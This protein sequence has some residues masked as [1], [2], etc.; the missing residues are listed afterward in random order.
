MGL[1]A[2]GRRAKGSAG[3]REAARAWTEGTGLPAR[4]GAQGGLSGGMDI[5]Q[6]A[7]V[8]LEAKRQEQLTVTR[9]LKQAEADARPGQPFAVVWRGNRMPWRVILRC[10]D[11][12]RFCEAVVAARRA[13]GLGPND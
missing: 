4:N 13:H 11:V 6:P 10:E 12:G 2:K 7:D 5:E 9:W 1:N 8:R 3:Q